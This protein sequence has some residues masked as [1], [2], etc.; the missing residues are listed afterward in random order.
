MPL[1]RALRAL[2]YNGAVFLQCSCSVL[3]VF[4]QCSRSVLAVSPRSETQ[5]PKLAHTGAFR[6]H[7]PTETRVACAAQ[8]PKSGRCSHAQ[9]GCACRNSHT[10][11]WT[12]SL[13]ACSARH[14]RSHRLTSANF[15][16]P[17][18]PSSGRFGEFGME[19]GRSKVS[20]PTQRRN[21]R[22]SPSAGDFTPIWPEVKDVFRNPRTMACKV[23]THLISAM[24]RSGGC[25][26]GRARNDLQDI[27][28]RSSGHL[29]NKARRG[30]AERG[31]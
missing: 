1:R 9:R 8:R 21:G 4:L 18:G 17:A 10:R 20:G 22:G 6:R 31:S 2:P 16:A 5:P 26:D 27:R 25:G 23:R 19:E 24:P 11:R 7:Q 3:A 15:V 28:R 12:A 29:K 13:S 30:R 14:I